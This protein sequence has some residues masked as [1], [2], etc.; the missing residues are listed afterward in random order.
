MFNTEKTA[1]YLQT[2]REWLK[3]SFLDLLNVYLLWNKRFK[4]FGFTLLIVTVIYGFLF[5]FQ[6]G[7]ENPIMWITLYKS[8]SMGI[9]IIAWWVTLLLSL[10]GLFLWWKLR[11]PQKP[12]TP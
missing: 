4:V 12:I 5:L 7:G 8:Y 3:Y 6:T 1:K 9:M 11:N 2:I 10:V